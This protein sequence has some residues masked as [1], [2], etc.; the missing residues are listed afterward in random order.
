MEQVEFIDALIL[1]N[2]SALPHFFEVWFDEKANIAGTNIKINWILVFFCLFFPIVGWALLFCM[3][4]DPV[5]QVVLY[6]NEKNVSLVQ[7]IYDHYIKNQQP[8]NIQPHLIIQ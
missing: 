4:T 5:T 1:T 2:K 6:S 7:Q 3:L 8:K